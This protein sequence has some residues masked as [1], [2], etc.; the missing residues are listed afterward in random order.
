MSLISSNETSNYLI[1]DLG[2]YTSNDQIK[3]SLKSNENNLTLELKPNQMKN[4]D[5][6]EILGLIIKNKKSITL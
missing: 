5:W 2:I 1:L 6:D 4:A 3:N